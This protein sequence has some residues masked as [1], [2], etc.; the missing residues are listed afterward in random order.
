MKFRMGNWVNWAIFVAVAVV[1]L[2]LLKNEISAWIDTISPSEGTVRVS[3]SNAELSLDPQTKTIKVG[4]VFTAEI[5]LDT[6]NKPVDGVD[7]YGLHYDPSILKVMDDDAKKAGTQIKPGTI[8]PVNTYNQVDEKT[9]TIKFSQV[10]GGGKNYMGHG[11]LA[12]IH[13]KA[14]AAG[15]DV[16][17]FDFSLGSTVDTN[18]PYKGKDQLRKVVDAI[19]TVEK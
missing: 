13:F 19:Y 5:M 17:K 16:L 15:I 2:F 6:A 11:V 4:D 10:A 18:A 12:V 3:K 1:V 7:V 14:L 8:M 9:G